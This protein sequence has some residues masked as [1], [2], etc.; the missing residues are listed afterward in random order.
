[1]ISLF[2]GDKHWSINKGQ[3]NANMCTEHYLKKQGKTEK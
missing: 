2:S 1:M 3:E